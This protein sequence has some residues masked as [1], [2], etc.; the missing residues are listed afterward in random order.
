MKEKIS[1]MGVLCTV[2]WAYVLYQ[3]YPIWRL[4]WYAHTNQ[5]DWW[6]SFPV[7]GEWVDTHSV[8]KT[9]VA[10]WDRGVF[11]YKTWDGCFL[12]MTIGSIPPSVFGEKYYCLTFSIIV[13]M[14]LLGA[15]SFFWVV[16]RCLGK[17]RKSEVLAVLALLTLIL[18]EMF[19]FIKEGYSW[20]VGG[21]NYTFFYGVFLLSQAF[22]VYYLVK[23]SKISLILGSILSFCV[24]LGNLLTGLLNPEV[25]IVEAVVLWLV[26]RFGAEKKTY[27]FKF[28]IPV[29]CSVVGLGINVLCPGNLLRG[30]GLLGNNPFLAIKD[31]I[32][33]STQMIAT[34]H[35]ASMIPIYL[36]M[37]MILLYGAVRAKSQVS[38]TFVHPVGV[39]VVLY[40]LYCS[41]ITPIVYVGTTIYGRCLNQ[42][43]LSQH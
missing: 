39:S 37:G 8:W 6:M 36:T 15:Y 4:S 32:V 17:Y 21:I 42:T 40:L 13:G 26:G 7:H 16:L 14:L 23:K 28:F 29:C 24:G 43:F 27:D 38:V 35:K 5:D 18:L 1:L 9:L 31:A 25:V 20:W 19:P 12:S 41:V 10:A 11:I 34:F 30:D 33:L 22:L 3:I 2:L